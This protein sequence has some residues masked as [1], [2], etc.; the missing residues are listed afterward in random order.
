MTATGRAVNGEQINILERVFAFVQFAG[1]I[2]AQRQWVLLDFEKL[3]H[4][5]L[6]HVNCD[7]EPTITIHRILDVVSI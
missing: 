5:Q 6:Q 7:A 4:L 1:D 2:S 3:F